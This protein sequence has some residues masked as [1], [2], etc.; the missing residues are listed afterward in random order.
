MNRVLY[1]GIRSQ[2]L[3][4]MFCLRRRAAPEST[5][6]SF[7]MGL[8]DTTDDHLRHLVHAHPKTVAMFTASGC[9]HCEHLRPVVETLA[10]NAAYES[11]AFVRLDAGQN[12][13]AQHLLAQNGGPFFVTYCR[14]RL[15][16]CETL[17]TE[18]QVRALL[19]ALL[20]HA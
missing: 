3:L 11:I 1:R 14:G 18:S 7:L 13:V 10:T 5:P 17:Y 20:A 4:P 12:P 8:T 2:P 9:P 16:H 19:H 15:L 6:T